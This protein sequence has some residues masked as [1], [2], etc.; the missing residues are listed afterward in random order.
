MDLE[1]LAIRFFT[2]GEDAVRSALQEITADSDK[3]GDSLENNVTKGFDQVK[4]KV[5][6][7]IGVW[8]AAELFKHMIEEAGELAVKLEVFSQ[9]T[10]ISAERLAEMGEQAELSFV[11]VDSLRSAFLRLG[12]SMGDS[13]SRGAL[14]MKAMGLNVESFH[15]DAEK[16]FTAIAEKFAT[17][18]DDLNKSALQTALFGRGGQ[19]TP[20]LNSFKQTQAEVKDLAQS[21]TDAQK[22]AMLDYERSMIR[23]KLV[24]D[25]FGRQVAAETAPALKALADSFTVSIKNGEDFNVIAEV[26]TGTIRFLG[27]VVLIL[28]NAFIL[29]GH[30][31]ADAFAALALG[32]EGLGHIIKDVITGNFKQIPIDAKTMMSQ[33]NQAIDEGWRDLIKDG[34]TASDELKSL[35]GFGDNTPGG[36]RTPGTKS[37]PMVKP[38]K[39]DNGKDLLKAM[40]D[41]YKQEA[42]VAKA[43]YELQTKIAQDLDTDTKTKYAK[44]EAQ[45]QAYLAF[46]VDMY[47]EGSKEYLDQLKVIEEH[48]K[49]HLD[50]KLKDENDYAK[51]IKEINDMVRGWEEVAAKKQKDDAEKFAKVTTN[52]IEAIFKEG[53]SKGGTIGSAMAAF[54]KTIAAG[55][56]GM[57]VQLG[58]TYLTYGTIMQS[59][60]ALLPDPFTAGAAGIAIGLALIAMGSALGA[61]ASGGGGGGGGGGPVGAPSAVNFTS[62]IN[63]A[64]TNAAGSTGSLSPTAPVAFTVIGANDPAAQRQIVQLITNANRRNIG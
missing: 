58:E 57:M 14:A 48:H 51:N 45:D 32:A 43:T 40:L 64:G 49:Q 30:Q 13:Q 61:V 7:L 33:V 26:L 23:L 60:A 36:K 1:T 11:P 29:L 6:E 52:S 62:S 44:I 54:G 18:R 42:E 22:T 56:G 21:M 5:I 63:P 37:A 24:T 10:G 2:Q 19:M 38:A 8:G 31:G 9:Q 53:F 50:A 34:K 12:M 25:G 3:V 47:D 27:S 41:M 55:L 39:E 15:G 16:A 59:L 20:L 46:I 35:F 17:Y 28:K 4:D